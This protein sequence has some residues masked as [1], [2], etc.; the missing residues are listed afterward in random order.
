MPHEWDEWLLREG[1][2]TRPPAAAVF[3]GEMSTV[4]VSKDVGNVR[5]DHPGLLNSK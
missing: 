3:A 1:P 5:N 4:P 2:R